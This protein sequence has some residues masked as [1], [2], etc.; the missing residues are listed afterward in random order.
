MAG[1]ILGTRFGRGI[2]AFVVALA[3]GGTVFLCRPPVVLVGDRAFTLVYGEKRSRAR[4]LVLSV[5]LFRP[6]KTVT[7]AEG[8]GPDLAAQ[9]AAARSRRPRGVFFPYR[10]REGARRYLRDRPGAPV[11]VLGGRRDAL[12]E[13]PGEGPEPLWLY[14][15]TLTDMY[16]AGAIAGVLAGEGTPALYRE[17]LSE[18]EK[19]AFSRGLG[20]SPLF[21]GPVRDAACV[22]LGG[23]GDD[24]FREETSAPLVLFTWTDPAFVPRT[25]AAVFDDSPWTQLRAGLELLKKGEGEGRVPSE[26]RVFLRAKEQKAEYKAVNR[27]K[28][29]KYS[30]ETA[31]N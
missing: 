25:T 10:Y 11:V 22:V 9:A 19:A 24:Y 31:D 23:P 21:S 28:T 15:D 6:V 12:A 27:L 2:L 7:L 16:R 17:G 8:A 29:L 30:D 20:R 5:L 3:L 13:G 26:I 14:T 18:A 1:K 4:Q